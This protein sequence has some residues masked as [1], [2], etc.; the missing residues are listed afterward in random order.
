MASGKRKRHYHHRSHSTQDR[1]LNSHQKRRRLSDDGDG[2]EHRPNSDKP[3]EN[4]SGDRDNDEG[5]TVVKTKQLK[6]RDGERKDGS[7]RKSNYPDL[8]IHQNYQSD[9]KLKD[10]R[11]LALY[12]LADEVAPRWTAISNSN[13][14]T[15]VVVV[16]VPGLDEKLLRQ[17]EKALINDP[18]PESK[19]TNDVQAL[20]KA[21]ANVNA[22]QPADGGTSETETPRRPLSWLFDH[23]IKVKGPGDAKMSKVHSPLQALLLAQEVDK[24]NP[25]RSGHSAERTPIS[26]FI[27]SAD[28]LR[29]AEFPIHPAAFTVQ[30]DAELEATRRARTGQSEADSWVDS[31]VASSQPAFGS[32][33]EDFISQGLSIYSIDCEMVQTSDEKNSL[34]RVSVIKYPSGTVVMDKYVKPDLPITNYFT[35]FSG[36]TPEIL[37]NVTTTLKDIQGELLKLFT[38]SAVLL[39]HSRLRPKRLEDDTPFLD[40]YIFNLSSSQRTSLAIILEISH[41][42]IPKTR[43]S[44]RRSEWP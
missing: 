39:G 27:H 23:V 19:P 33:S 3:E 7:D 31:Q 40:R 12:L 16:M 25:S 28:E 24:T 32:N 9:V 5:W 8:R 38:P 6:S 20:G 15:K 44:D 26:D 22:D 30:L 41:K 29:E 4:V 1:D 21:D 18:V 2:K 36:I 11:D 10:L 34:A 13:Q 35:Q 17:V 42:Q 14:I 43:D 37:A